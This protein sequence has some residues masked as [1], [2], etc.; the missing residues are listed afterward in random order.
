MNERG[1]DVE[2]PFT[3]MHGLGNDYIYVNGFEVGLADPSTVA[4]RI[5]DRH[6]GVGSDGLVLILPSDRA[7][8]R[9]RMWNPDGSE[10]EQ[11]GNALRCIARYVYERGL[12]DRTAFTIET[13][14]GQVKAVLDLLP[15]PSGGRARVG[16][17]ETDLGPPVLERER[18][19]LQGSPPAGRVI[20]ERWMVDGDPLT[21]SAVSMGNPHLVIEVDSV[22]QAPVTTLGPRLEHDPRFPRRTNVGFVEVSAPDHLRLRVWERG[23]GETLACGSGA[24]AATVAMVLRGRAHSPLAIDL[25]GGRLEAAWREGEGVRIKGPAAFICDGVFTL[26]G[27][28][29]EA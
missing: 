17:V 11:C 14:A 19:P 18:I 25:P 28:T 24:A 9:M 27:A 7:D 22:A 16:A 20:G 1:V 29:P 4:Q 5:S 8:F 15:A 3:K 21:V 12:T 6:R 2:I 23:T 13:G 10:S 26:D